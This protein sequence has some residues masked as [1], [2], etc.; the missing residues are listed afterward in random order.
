MVRRLPLTM[1]RQCNTHL[2]VRSL[3][4]T[5][6]TY[7][8]RA[9][10]QR[11]AP[12]RA[13]GHERARGGRGGRG[14]GGGSLPRRQTSTGVGASRRIALRADETDTPELH[15][16]GRVPVEGE[17]LEKPQGPAEEDRKGRAL[18]ASEERP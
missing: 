18:L 6:M 9:T 5:R 2:S 14:G 11:V 10:P 1:I 17:A 15:E 13:S 8:A 7:E 3:I 12:A 16:V 4:V